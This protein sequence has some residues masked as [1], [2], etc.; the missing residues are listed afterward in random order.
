MK[1]LLFH[2]VAICS[3]LIIPKL[4]LNHRLS[5]RNGPVIINSS[6][7]EETRVDDYFKFAEDFT[8]LSN[9]ESSLCAQSNET[10]YVCPRSIKSMVWK[11]ENLRREVKFRDPYGECI[12]VGKYDLTNDSYG[13]EMKECNESNDNQIFILFGDHGYNGVA[14]ISKK[15][16]HWVSEEE[17]DH[18]RKESLRFNP[19]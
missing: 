17:K 18:F 14:E 6:A 1:L 5:Y 15:N 10:L 9:S 12:T 8:Y 2:G 7:N 16:A 4:H 13:I 19:H 11:I 3:T